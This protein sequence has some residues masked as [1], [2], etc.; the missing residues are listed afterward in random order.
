MSVCVLNNH[1]HLIGNVGDG[2]V[3]EY[4]VIPFL[5][6]FSMIEES[7]PEIFLHLSGRGSFCDLQPIIDA[8]LNSKVPV[9][10]IV[11]NT[12]KIGGFNGVS[13]NLELLKDAIKNVQYQLEEEYNPPFEHSISEIHMTREHDTYFFSKEEE[14]EDE[15][16]IND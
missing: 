4:V 14:F 11:Q 2:Y 3:D 7:Y 8:V 13:G 6:T 9:N 12:E 5:T 1:I 15:E 10:C 16:F